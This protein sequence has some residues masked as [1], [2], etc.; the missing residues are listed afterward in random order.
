MRYKLLYHP[1]VRRDDIPRLSRSARARIKSAIE[2]KLTTHPE[3]YG[4]PLRTS[5]R[6][7]RKL[8]VGD[9]RIVFRI[10]KEMVH[11]FAI[12][13]RSTVYQQVQKRV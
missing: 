8:R 9:Y 4:K 2:H 1:H 13:H 7:Y 11:I 6:G 3:I 12:V 5:L 10:E